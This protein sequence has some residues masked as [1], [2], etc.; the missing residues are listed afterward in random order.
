[1]TSI[2]PDH[3]STGSPL[4]SISPDQQRGRIPPV[5]CSGGR[6][7]ASGCEHFTRPAFFHSTLSLSISPDRPEHSTR[8]GEHFTRRHEH[9]TRP[10]KV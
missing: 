2:P 9:S 6:S 10:A 7:T 1:M 4:A 3:N 5:R 8:L